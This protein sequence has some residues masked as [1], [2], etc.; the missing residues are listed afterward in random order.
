MYAQ[1]PYI[2]VFLDEGLLLHCDLKSWCGFP[3]LRPRNLTN[4]RR[5]HLSD[6]F[7]VFSFCRAGANSIDLKSGKFCDLLVVVVFH[8]ALCWFFILL[9]ESQADANREETDYLGRDK[10]HYIITDP[11]KYNV[12]NRLTWL[13]LK[14]LKVLKVQ[15]I[16]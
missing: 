9:V 10:E 2:Q 16:A 15:I 4:G 6:L 13:Q 1:R 3:F 7:S 11:I 12:V 14:R 5:I 8:A